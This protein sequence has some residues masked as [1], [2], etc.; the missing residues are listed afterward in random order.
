MSN[1]LVTGDDLND[2]LTSV[3]DYVDHNDLDF[4]DAT[5]ED[6]FPLPEL[7]LTVNSVEEIHIDEIINKY[8]L[9]E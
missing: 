9:K 7:S 5:Y 2:I 4:S 8:F 3:K 6:K 1:R